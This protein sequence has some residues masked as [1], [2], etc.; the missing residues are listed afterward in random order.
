MANSDL[1]SRKQA[2]TLLK[3]QKPKLLTGLDPKK[4][5]EV[6]D[7]VGAILRDTQVELSR[8]EFRTHS[9]PLPPSDELLRYNE[10]TP[11]AADRIITLAEKQQ[12]HRIEME[13]HVI[14]CQQVQSARGQV[15]GGLLS[16]FLIGSG[17]WL[18][19]TGHD[20]VAGVVFG[21]TVIGLAALFVIGKVVQRNDLNRKK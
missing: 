18:A 5:N 2:E 3:E 9:G 1:E 10:A 14:R 8:T 17:T 16:S 21:T 7:F 4:R 20:A 6:I 15:I 13:T 12:N 11:D 19:V